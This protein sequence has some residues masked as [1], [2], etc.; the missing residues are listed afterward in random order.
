LRDILTIGL[1]SF[2]LGAGILAGFV[3]L[4]LAA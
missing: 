1:Y 4:L 3:A 2:G